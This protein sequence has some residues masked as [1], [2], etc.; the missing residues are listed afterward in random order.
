[1]VDYIDGKLNGRLS[2][3]MERH[4]SMCLECRGEFEAMRQTTEAV[5]VNLHGRAEGLEPPDDL[6]EKV[7]EGIRAERQDLK[8][9]ADPAW[10]VPIVLTPIFVVILMITIFSARYVMMHAGPMDL[11]RPTRLVVNA[12]KEG[13]LSPFKGGDSPA[14]D[15]EKVDA[16]GG[17]KDEPLYMAERAG[18]SALP[19]SSGS[20]SRFVGVEMRDDIIS[21]LSRRSVGPPLSVVRKE[22]RSFT[23]IYEINGRRVKVTK[24]PSVEGVPI[25][26]GRHQ[27]ETI[28]AGERV[29]TYMQEVSSGKKNLI[30]S[31]DK[32]MYLMEADMSREEMIKT[33]L[34]LFASLKGGE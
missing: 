29:A 2:E 24:F 13:L 15:V 1:M 5:R 32:Y 14:E 21:S 10:Y 19:A 28:P 11:S 4:L 27:V 8:V 18:L 16:S 23:M 26:E 12:V 7:L 6:W 3:E 31:D 20:E 9:E 22:Q 34:L 33:F 17:R 25:P 30:Y